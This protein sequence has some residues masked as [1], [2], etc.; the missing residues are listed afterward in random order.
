MMNRRKTAAIII[1]LCLLSIGIPG[2]A[3]LFD[4]GSY[5]G[6]GPSLNDGTTL[7]WAA[8]PFVLDSDSYANNFGTALSRSVQDTSFT[9]YLTPSLVDISTSALAQWTIFPTGP[10]MQYYYVQPENPILLTG[11]TPYFLVVM[12]SDADSYG[13]ISYSYSGYYG[14]LSGDQG[15]TWYKQA[16]PFSL[17]VDGTLVPEPGGLS[18]LVIGV[19]VILLRLGSAGGT[20]SRLTTHNS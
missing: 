13:G 2:W 5:V 17:R 15:E 3:W 8:A 1:T 4:G 9:V 11:G 14:F 19:I 20:P 7:Y 6:N 10:V 16:L 18:I 12:P